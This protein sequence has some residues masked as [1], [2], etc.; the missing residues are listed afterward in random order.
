MG[1]RQQALQLLGQHPPT[2]EMRK[3]YDD[4]PGTVN[5]ERRSQIRFVV[6]EFLKVPGHFW[7]I[8][9]PWR[10]RSRVPRSNKAVP[11]EYT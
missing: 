6:N 11:S 5:V 2:V 3:K 9:S 4:M 8:P 1:L 10:V 7:I